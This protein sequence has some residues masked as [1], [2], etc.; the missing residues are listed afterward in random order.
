[1]S[2]TANEGRA[3]EL[4][5]RAIECCND[6]DFDAMVECF[7]ED[8][9]VDLAVFGLGVHVGQG[10]IK[11]FLLDWIGSCDKVEFSVERLDEVDPGV[12]WAL[13]HQQARP[14]GTTRSLSLKYTAVYVW[15]EE[16][17]VQATHYPDVAS[18]RAAAVELAAPV[19]RLATAPGARD[20]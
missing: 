8:S 20:R 9:V 16:S 18:A 2:A 3:G 4:T 14:A 12:A 13:V 15:S 11:R 19:D 7:A 5:R 1:M 10:A 6:R 17:V